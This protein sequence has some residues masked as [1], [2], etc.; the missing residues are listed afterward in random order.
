M[1]IELPHLALITRKY[2]LYNLSLILHPDGS[3][4]IIGRSTI[5]LYFRISFEISIALIFDLELQVANRM[6]IH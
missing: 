5:S 4:L 6:R 1:N 3:L 2:H